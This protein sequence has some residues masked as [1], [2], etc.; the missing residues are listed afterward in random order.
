M[1]NI[2]KPKKLNNIFISKII[3]FNRQ[4]NPIYI[5]LHL[6]FKFIL[7]NIYTIY[8]IKNI[9]IIYSIKNQ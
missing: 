5:Y 8:K 1:K 2:Q 3:N 4:A 9:N 7:F 6:F